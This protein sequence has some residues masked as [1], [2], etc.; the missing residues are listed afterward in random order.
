MNSQN[1]YEKLQ[2][3]Q[4]PSLKWNSIIEDIIGLYD[5]QFSEERIFTSEEL[6]DFLFTKRDDHMIYHS[7]IWNTFIVPNYYSFFCMVY[8]AIEDPEIGWWNSQYILSIK[9]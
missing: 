4:I 8:K 7:K 5:Y 9:K 1:F 6:W 3:Y 2:K